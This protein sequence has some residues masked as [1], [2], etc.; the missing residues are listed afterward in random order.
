MKLNH[1]VKPNQLDVPFRAPAS[2]LGARLEPAAPPNGVASTMAWQN[3]P[4]PQEEE[5]LS[6]P[7][8]DPYEASRQKNRR[9]AI[10]A[11][12]SLLK[13]ALKDRGIPVRTRQPLKLV[14]KNSG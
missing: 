8:R 13:D 11:A 6:R 7:R 10:L 5:T 9:E 4:L 1:P 14:G 3:L 2:S 12:G